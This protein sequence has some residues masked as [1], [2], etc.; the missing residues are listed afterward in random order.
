MP[1]SKGICCWILCHKAVSGQSQIHSVSIY[2]MHMS[3][4]LIA[5]KLLIWFWV[6]YILQSH[7]C[8]KKI[9]YRLFVFSRL[10]MW[11]SWKFTSSVH[12]LSGDGTAGRRSMGAARFLSPP[13][14]LIPWW[15]EWEGRT[16]GLLLHVTSTSLVE[17]D[18]LVFLF[19]HRVLSSVKL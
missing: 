16:I 8:L 1:S 18:R 15:R 4:N 6:S 3:P 7:D 10:T 12:C 17:G 9:W 13:L 2:M 19:F 11:F 14:K 5:L